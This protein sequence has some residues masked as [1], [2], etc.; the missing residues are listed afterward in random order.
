M[1]QHSDYNVIN[2]A[3]LV[4]DQLLLSVYDVIVPVLVSSRN[5]ASLKPPICS[6]RICSGGRIVEVPLHHRR[7]TD[8][9]FARLPGCGVN[10]AV[11]ITSDKASFEVRNKYA[12]AANLS[13]AVFGWEQMRHG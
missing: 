2:D 6:D 10:D 1:S 7:P 12:D 5:I 11:F 8:P 3:C 13:Q 4:L 9:E